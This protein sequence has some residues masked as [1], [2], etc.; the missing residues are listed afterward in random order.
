MKAELERLLLGAILASK[1]AQ[2]LFDASGLTPDDFSDTSLRIAVDLAR[3][4]A[5]RHMPTDPVSVWSTGRAG[6]RMQEDDLGWLNSVAASN[7]LDERA[8]LNLAEQLRNQVRGR[9]A[10]ARLRELATELE[11]PGARFGPIASQLEGTAISL[12][13]GYQANRT[14]ENDPAE[15]LE[16]WEQNAKAGKTLYVPTGI[17]VW[18]KAFTGY[19]PNFNL[20]IGPP[21]VGKS[22]ILAS[23]IYS[24]L[25]Q[26]M[27]VGLFG[28][29]DGH[30]WLTRRYIAWR[31]GL[32]VR[33][34]GNTQLP[35]EG[36]EK[37]H[38]I[39]AELSPLL[40]NLLVYKW[41]GA[42]AGEMCRWGLSWIINEGCQC[43]YID[44]ASNMSHEGRPGEKHFDFR[45]QVSRS[46][47]QLR[48]FAERYGVP[49]VMLAH[50]TREYE[51]KRAFQ[52]PLPSDTAEGAAFER[53]TRFFMGFWQ[54]RWSHELRATLG[55]VNESESG[56][57]FGFERFREAALVDLGSGRLI[58]VREEQKKEAADKRARAME[59]GVLDAVERAKLK[60]QITGK[61]KEEEKKEEP[62]PEPPAPQLGLDLGQQPK[63]EDTQ[64]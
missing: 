8:F 39:G 55:K 31:A 38:G 53:H 63:A 57:T 58:D 5:E 7:Q 33:D 4:R 45:I 50:T 43:I 29:E 34:V 44:N 35:P 18:D 60:A 14:A 54:R 11:A 27:R 3:R 26:G 48:N 13:R 42:T 61:A 25:A 28:L 23:G 30:R 12:F 10:A 19:V 22:A 41:G 56:L 2:R 6:R 20:M 37:V 9:R 47:E 46:V 24:Q 17:P 1:D 21:A 15:V 49:V 59:A 51:E 32:K 40:R 36:W 52:P 16:Q 64:K 62:T